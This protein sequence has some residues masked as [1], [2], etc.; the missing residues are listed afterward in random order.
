MAAWRRGW[1]LLVILD[2]SRGISYFWRNGFG[3]KT[4]N[5]L[6]GRIW[7]SNLEDVSQLSMA[8]VLFYKEDFVRPGLESSRF[9]YSYYLRR[10]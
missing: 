6:L 3:C 4:R 1:N 9:V 8:N 10:I 2:F 5:V 7:R